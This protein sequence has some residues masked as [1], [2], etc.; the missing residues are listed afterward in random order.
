[1]IINYLISTQLMEVRLILSLRAGKTTL[2]I[3]IKSAREPDITAIRRLLRLSKGI[4][5][6]QPYV[7]CRTSIASEV[8][9]VRVL[10]WQQ[11]VVEL[12]AGE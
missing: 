2:A 11:G 4:D 10:P 3:E 8:E 5:N 7:F 12:F 9:G 1:M 6:C